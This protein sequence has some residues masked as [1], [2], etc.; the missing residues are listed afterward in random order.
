MWVEEVSELWDLD[1]SHMKRAWQ[2]FS[3]LLI[4]RVRLAKLVVCTQNLNYCRYY[5]KRCFVL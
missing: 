3:F 2:F 1:G 4:C 5:H